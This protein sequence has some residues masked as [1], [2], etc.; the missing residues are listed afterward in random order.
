[1]S[2]ISGVRWMLA[3]LAVTL[4]GCGRGEV[5]QAQERDGVRSEVREQLGAVPA[6]LDTATAARLSGAFR[7]AADRALPAVVFVRVEQEARVARRRVPNPFFRF[8]PELRPDEE[9]ELPPQQGQGSG[10]IF[11][12][13]GYIMTNNHVVQNA[14]EVTVRLVDGREFVAEVIGSDPNTDVAVIKI[15]PSKAES[16]P[17]AQFGDA[18]Q[19]RVGDWVLALGS[20]LG[21]TFS[22]TAGIVSAKG[23]SLGI[24]QEVGQAPL[25]AFI[26][27]DAA[28]N[29]GNSGGPLVDLLG[30]VVGINTAI[31]SPTGVFAGAGFAIPINLGSRVARDLIEFGAVRRPRLGVTIEAVTAVDA[32]VY[33]LEKIAGAE[34]T[35]VQSGTPAARAGL[36]PGDVIMAVDGQ[37]VED[38]TELQTMLAGRRPGERVKLT[39]IRERRR[40]VVDVELGEF[41]TAAARERERGGRPGAEE[42]LGFEVETLTPTLADRLELRERRGVVIS[43][44]RPFGSAAQANVRPGL[45]LL[46]INGQKVETARDVERIAGALKPGDV[47]SLRVR[48]PQ[49]EGAERVINYR[50]HR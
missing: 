2:R 21:L 22:V 31:T 6:V 8:F 33:G 27:T 26:Q 42:L 5:A 7:A 45:L 18:E 39:L 35:S 36:Q 4:P 13:R 10:F 34:V 24:L 25:E 23:R 19:L 40:L 37:A 3:A 44:V 49:L 41:E 20:P 46:S 38:A 50:T 29:P 48:D 14:A 9:M 30:R 28:I 32:E 17:T 11:D 15:N 12:K 1:M 16:L 43:G 47:V